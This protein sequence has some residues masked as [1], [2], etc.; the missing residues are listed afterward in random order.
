MHAYATPFTCIRLSHFDLQ[1]S[2]G[3]TTTP[4]ARRPGSLA[5]KAQFS[6]FSSPTPV[7][8]SGAEAETV[9]ALCHPLSSISKAVVL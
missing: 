9:T 3:G 8:L 5:T 2:D 6:L 1:A 7:K 4:P